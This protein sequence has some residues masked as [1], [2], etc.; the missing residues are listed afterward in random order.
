M[1]LPSSGCCYNKQ[2]RWE[3]AE[4]IFRA[5]LA[6]QANVVGPEHPDS[7]ETLSNLAHAVSLFDSS[8]SFKTLNLAFSLVASAA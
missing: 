8:N 3:E 7:L 1:W 2:G 6:N 5:V 4:A